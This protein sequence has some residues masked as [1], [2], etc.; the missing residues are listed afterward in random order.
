[1]LNAIAPTDRI[2]SP[3]ISLLLSTARPLG[4]PVEDT[5]RLESSSTNF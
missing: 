3:F 5:T 4:N 1:M 2:P